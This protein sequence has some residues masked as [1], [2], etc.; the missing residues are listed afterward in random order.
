MDD[1]KDLLDEID[2]LDDNEESVKE[3]EEQP[4][5]H[6]KAFTVI[7]VIIIIVALAMLYLFYKGNYRTV[8]SKKNAQRDVSEYLDGFYDYTNE[9]DN[10]LDDD[11]E[12]DAMEEYEDYEELEKQALA[13]FETQKPNL[14]VTNQSMSIDNEL[15]AVIH[16]GNQERITDITVQ[17]I[18]YNSENIP[19][20]I[21]ED[22]IDMDANSDAYITFYETPKEYARCEFLIT[23]D[24]LI[25]DETYISHKSDVTFES[26]EIYGLIEIIAKNNSNEEIDCI[27][28]EVV[29]YNENNQI[30]GTDF[31][32]EYEI[33]PNSSFEMTF[34]RN[35]YKYDTGEDVLAARYEVILQEAATYKEEI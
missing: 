30:I 3:K 23:K 17:V 5:S 13:K 14:V 34:D 28:F 7:V 31:V 15:I 12:N 20:K 29:Y 4:T 32:E 35:L 25:E 9:E 18:F 10:D 8:P 2:K 1:N 26:K 6:E 33:K 21:D 11:F 24:F 19:I 27:E 22:Y 16:N